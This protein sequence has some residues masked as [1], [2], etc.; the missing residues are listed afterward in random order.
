MSENGSEMNMGAIR[1]GPEPNIAVDYMGEGPLVVFLHGIGGNRTNWHD[2]LPIFAEHFTAATW[3]ARGWGDS[4][5]YNGPLRFGD[6][7]DDLCRVLDHFGATSAHLVGLSMGGMIVQEFAARY[8]NRVGAMVLVDTNNGSMSE[9]EI[10]GF[11]KM[12][13]EPLLAG[14]EPKDIADGI[15][16]KLVSPSASEEMVK[17]LVDSISA[18][19]KESYIK[20]IETVAHFEGPDLSSLRTP[21]LVI[22][23]SDDAI[24]PPSVHREM[25]QQLVQARYLEIPDAGH[26][27]NMEKPAEFNQAVL[28]FLFGQRDRAF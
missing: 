11:V 26:L 12:R 16:R 7:C 27:S 17:R 9:A 10:E 23:G 1:I 5:D 14:K 21:S 18:L 20:A 24:T 6:V 8:P 19:H 25:V 13:R 4:D 28:N 2:Q 22:V 15:A 3:D